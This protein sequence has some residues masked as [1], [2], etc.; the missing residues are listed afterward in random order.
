MGGLLCCLVQPAD[1]RGAHPSLSSLGAC[2]AFS[3]LGDA[4]GVEL[5]KNLNLLVPP[6]CV[7]LQL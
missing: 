4:G 3:A 5:G 2:V 7:I 1:R 6:S